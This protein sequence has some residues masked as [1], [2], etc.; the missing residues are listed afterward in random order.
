MKGLVDDNEQIIEVLEVINVSISSVCI[1]LFYSML[2]QR[3][4]QDLEAVKF[5]QNDLLF[6]LRKDQAMFKYLAEISPCEFKR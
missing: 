6:L 3:K 4:L 5:R 1:L 2:S